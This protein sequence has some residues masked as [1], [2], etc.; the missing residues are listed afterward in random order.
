[1]PGNGSWWYINRI[2]DNNDGWG[3]NILLIAK[4]QLVKIDVVVTHLIRTTEWQKVARI[5][6]NKY[7]NTHLRNWHTDPAGIPLP[8]QSSNCTMIGT[9]TSISVSYPLGPPPGAQTPTNHWPFMGIWNL[10]STAL[11]KQT[12]INLFTRIVSIYIHDSFPNFRAQT[13]TSQTTKL[14]FYKPLCF[15]LFVFSLLR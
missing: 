4:C 3:K 6:V 10:W 15:V 11:I 13:R 9:F 7:I 12:I 5:L 1:M 14:Y 2:D 8:G